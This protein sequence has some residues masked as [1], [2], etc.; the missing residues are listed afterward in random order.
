MAPSPDAGTLPI[1]DAANNKVA[2]DE[3]VSV[4]DGDT[5]EIHGQRIRLSGI[6]APAN[7]IDAQIAGRPLEAVGSLLG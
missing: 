6:G 4:I 7:E 3:Q 1:T 5:I 2:R